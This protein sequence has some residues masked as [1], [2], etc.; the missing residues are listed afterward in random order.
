MSKNGDNMLEMFIVED[1]LQGTHNPVAK[2]EQ[3]CMIENVLYEAIGEGTIGMQLVAEV[4]LNRVDNGYYQNTGEE[5]CRVVYRPDQFSWTLIPQG[6]R[7][8]YSEEEYMR[9]AQVV[10]SV[11]Y[12]AVER[13]LPPTVLHYINPRH[14]T[15]M[16]WYDPSKVVYRHKNHDFVQL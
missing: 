1:M 5:L 12:D 8:V 16:S 11:L 10:L 4:T 15:D 14:A 9:A 2:A 3:H 6:D 13:I 7:L